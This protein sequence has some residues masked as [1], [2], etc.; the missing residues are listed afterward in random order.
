MKHLEFEVINEATPG[1]KFSQLFKNNWPVYRTWYLDE[2]EAARPTYLECI[3]ALKKYMPALVPLY[4]QVLELLGY[5]DL[6]ARFLSLYHPPPFYS[7]CSQLITKKDEKVLIRNYDFPPILREGTVLQSQWRG[8]GVIAMA[9]CV[10]GALDG[11]N[12]SGLAIS[13][14]YGGR[15]VQGDGFGITIVLRYVLETCATVED[16]YNLRIRTIKS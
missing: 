10:W 3:T 2:G 6:Q 13:I 11:M 14:A 1:E 16:T 12:D 9:D 8:K 4:H 15:L 7:G 5:D